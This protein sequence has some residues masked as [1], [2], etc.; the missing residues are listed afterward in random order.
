MEKKESN[1]PYT[2]DTLAIHAYEARQ[3][4]VNDKFMDLIRDF[5]TE[6]VIDPIV[7]QE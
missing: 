5:D 1:T 4:I 3:K 7:D 6:I 2:W